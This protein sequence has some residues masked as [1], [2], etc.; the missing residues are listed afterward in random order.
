MT[1]IALHVVNDCNVRLNK[2][3]KVAMANKPYYRQMLLDL[4]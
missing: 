1:T 2:T 3:M 4:C